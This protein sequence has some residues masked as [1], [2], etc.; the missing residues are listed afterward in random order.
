MLL[1]EIITKLGARAGFTYNNFLV[2]SKA[3]NNTLLSS[4]HIGTVNLF[5]ALSLSYIS[6]TGF[7]ILLKDTLAEG[8]R[9]GSNRRPSGQWTTRSTS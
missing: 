4:T 9:P 3:L 2:N 8:R 1:N 7:S 5:A 6:P